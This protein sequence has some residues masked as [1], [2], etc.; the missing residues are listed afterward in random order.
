MLSEAAPSTTIARLERVVA[1]PPA[2]APETIASTAIAP[3]PVASVPAAASPTDDAP[4]TAGRRVP[5]AAGADD[6]VGRGLAAL[7]RRELADAEA[8]LH[9]AAAEHPR[10]VTVLTALSTLYFELGQ[11][12]RAVEYGELA[13][14]AG[15]RN[16]AAAL[17]LG[18][19]YF[20]VLRYHDARASY[21]AADELG[22]RDAA[23]R[24]ARVDDKLGGGP[25]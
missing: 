11:Y 10:S 8:L 25:R 14:R 23:K 21:V 13:V 9:R 6:L 15:P 18:D 12:A 7:R 4:Q 3:A 2:A 20:K 24:L 17:A 5:D 22:S 1:A 16:A 19:A